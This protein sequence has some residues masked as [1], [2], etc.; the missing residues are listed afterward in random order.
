[1]IGSIILNLK[2]IFFEFITL[3][4]QSLSRTC[5]NIFWSRILL[6]LAVNSASCSGLLLAG[7]LLSSSSP[8]V[9]ARSKKR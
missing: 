9:A 1:M 4:P 3:C 8:S 5:M 7:P 2:N 6:S